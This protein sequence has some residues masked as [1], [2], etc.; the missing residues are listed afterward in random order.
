M[1]LPA[2][3]LPSFVA[4]IE[5][6]EIREWASPA[7]MSFPDF[8]PLNPGYR[9][10]QNSGADRVARTIVLRREAASTSFPR[11][12]ES[13]LGPRLRG[14]ERKMEPLYGRP[15]LPLIPAQAGIQPGSPP[16]RGR[17]ENGTVARHLPRFVGEDKRMLRRNKFHATLA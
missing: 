2:F 1:R 16:P 17:A 6:S 9:R 5:R 10:W 14:D 4:R 11:K 3:R 12:R 13:S 7:S 15:P 8:A